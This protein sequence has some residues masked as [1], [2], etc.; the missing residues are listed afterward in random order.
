MIGAE[1]DIKIDYS[2]GFAEDGVA[3]YC[4]NLYEFAKIPYPKTYITVLV[5]STLSFEDA[6]TRALAIYR[7][8]KA[9]IPPPEVI[10]YESLWKET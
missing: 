9:G 5:C 7:L 2:V 10:T 1:L 3:K 6:K 4:V 8:K